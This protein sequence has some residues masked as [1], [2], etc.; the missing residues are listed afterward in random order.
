MTWMSTFESR[1]SVDFSQ[2][3]T[4][5][6]GHTRRARYSK[7]PNP[8]N[9]NYY[10]NNIYKFTERNMVEKRKKSP[11]SRG[12]CNYRHLKRKTML[13]EYLAYKRR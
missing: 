4:R 12:Y 7:P 13:F 10:I 6:F 9:V 5:N 2:D 11:L 3:R 1:K 8:T